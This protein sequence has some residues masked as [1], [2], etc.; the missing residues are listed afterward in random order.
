MWEA[1]SASQESRRGNRNKRLRRR[2]NHWTRNRQKPLARQKGD[3]SAHRCGSDEW[4]CD[5][6]GIASHHQWSKANGS[7][8]GKTV[9]NGMR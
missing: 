8:P 6:P 2:C 4:V 3:N 5:H 9:G 1:S 7:N